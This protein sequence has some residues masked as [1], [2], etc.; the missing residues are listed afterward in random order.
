MI[1]ILLEHLHSKNILFKD[2]YSSSFLVDELSN[3]FKIL[4]AFSFGDS[5]DI[6]AIT[7]GK[8]N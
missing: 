2:V 5:D 6:R 1:L 8:D 4:K 7:E 3:G